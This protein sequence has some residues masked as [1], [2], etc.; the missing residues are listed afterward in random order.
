[1]SY[2]FKI[3]LIGPGSVG[4][5]SLVNRFVHNRFSSSYEMTM[6]VDIMNKKIDIED[7]SVTLTIWDIGGQER[8]KYL[9]RNFYR[10]AK[11]ALL[12]FDLSRVFT[13]E[14]LTKKWY[15]EMLK[16]T[17][18]E[19]PFILIGNKLDLISEVGRIFEPNISSEFA[20]EKGSIYIETSAKTNENVEK[21]F[22]ELTKRI[23]HKM[24]AQ[25]T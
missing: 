21:A 7:T 14:N 15:A 25:E 13:Y 20:N 3:I 5:T 22:I 2:Q 6:G 12:I 18:H 23:T 19:I 10:G 24:M 9:R 1:M 8:F 11:G 16:Y 17:K 4:K